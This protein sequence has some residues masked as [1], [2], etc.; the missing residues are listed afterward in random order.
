[1]YRYIRSNSQFMKTYNVY[2]KDRFYG[3]VE[4]ESEEDA[5]DQYE[6]VIPAYELAT[7]DHDYIPD[8]V[9]VIPADEDDIE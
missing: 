5:W 3:Q 8:Y 9:F 4:A 7:V 2:F 6:D 1:M